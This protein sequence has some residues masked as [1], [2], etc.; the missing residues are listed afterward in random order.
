M[1]TPLV[2]QITT[3]LP[4]SPYPSG[5]MVFAPF[6]TLSLPMSLNALQFLYMNQP[7]IMVLCLLY[8]IPV[9]GLHIFYSLLIVLMLLNKYHYGNH[10]H[11][12]S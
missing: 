12:S 8:M 6:I 5:A 1:A 2:S 9:A 11:L 10:A 3:S 4:C 7:H